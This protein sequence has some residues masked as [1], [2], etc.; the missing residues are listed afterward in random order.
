MSA[1]PI[2]LFFDEIDGLVE[3]TLI[4]LLKQF[5]TGYTKRPKLFPQSICLIGVRNLQDYKLLSIEEEERGILLSPFNIVADMLVLRN[6]TKEQVKELYLQHTKDS[7][8][9]F[10]D[11]A[12]EYAH[13]ITQGQPW[14]VN[15]LAYQA[16][17]RDVTDRAQPITK[18]VME[19]AKEQLILRQDTH[20]NALVD[21]LNEPRVRNIIDAI[22]S[23]TEPV[24]LNPDDLQYVR[25]L[26]LLKE[27]SWEIANPIYQQVIPR[28]LTA[29]IQGMIP[30]KQRGMLMRQVH[31]I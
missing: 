21:R 24:Y 16:C 19:R 27:D 29:M 23:G 18:E 15:A 25:D 26:G 9:Q 8:Q 14:L 11:E 10:T 28:A 17:F 5:R 20:I 6:F 3:N 7:G 31:L 12:L 2:V 1:K 13:H 4:S 22:I 30:Q